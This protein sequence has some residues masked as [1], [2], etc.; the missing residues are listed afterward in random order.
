VQ[1]AFPT[2]RGLTHGGGGRTRHD[3]DVSVAA[4]LFD[5]AAPLRKAFCPT[6]Q[7]TIN[8]ENFKH[9]RSSRCSRRNALLPASIKTCDAF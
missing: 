4:A 7:R 8:P 9:S 6:K 3:C 2:R 5:F 1:H